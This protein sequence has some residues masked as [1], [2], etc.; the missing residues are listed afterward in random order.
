MHLGHPVP[1]RVHDQL[2]GVR[3]ASVEAVAGTGEILVEPQVLVDQAV[4]GGVVDAAEIDRRTELVAFG[5]VVVDHVEDDLDALL[6]ERPDHGLEFGH[7]TAAL[8]VGG[9]L[10]VRCEESEGVV[11]PVVSQA[12]VQQP[13]VVHELMHRHQFDRGDIQRFEMIDDRRVSQAGVGAAERFGDSGMGLGHPLDVRL[14][15]HR[16]VIRPAR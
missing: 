2:Q 5:G 9:V 4:V 13:A 1:Q 10:V 8:S 3:V 15:D 7:R 6:V 11:A 16:L 14:V 12:Q